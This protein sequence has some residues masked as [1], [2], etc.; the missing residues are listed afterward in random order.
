MTTPIPRDTERVA[1]ATSRRIISSQSLFG[2]QREVV[3]EHGGEEY[4]LRVTSNKKLIL[5]K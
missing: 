1:R 4:R 3:I 2:E 5:T